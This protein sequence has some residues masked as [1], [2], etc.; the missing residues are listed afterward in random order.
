[1]SLNPSEFKQMVD[2]IRKCELSLENFRRNRFKEKNS[3]IRKKI[4][5]SK[6]KY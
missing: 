2:L 5:S 6:N 4:D 1:M 3:S